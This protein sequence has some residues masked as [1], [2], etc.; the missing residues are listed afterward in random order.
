MVPNSLQTTLLYLFSSLIQ[1]DAAILS[2]GAFFVVYKIQSLEARIP[3]AMQLLELRK[4]LD[5]AK[6]ALMMGASLSE[7]AKFI[8]GYPRGQIMRQQMELIE[9]IPKRVQE[10]KLLLKEPIIIIA[11]HAVFCT[12]GLWLNQFISESPTWAH[13][14]ICFTILWFAVGM[15]K[16]SSLALNLTVKEDELSLERLDPT[17][18]SAIQEEAKKNKPA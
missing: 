6:V 17:L 13:I 3:Q 7:K 1:A 9:A 11:V 16:A 15:W 5:N 18:F 2:F 14:F 4:T 12:V 10:V 8:A